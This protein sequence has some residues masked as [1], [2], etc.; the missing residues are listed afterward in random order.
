MTK[1]EGCGFSDWSGKRKT[2]VAFLLFVCCFLPA[3]LIAGP[4]FGQEFAVHEAHTELVNEV[5]QLDAWIDIRLGEEVVDA[6]QS[7]VPITIE[8]DIEVYRPRRYLWNERIASLRQR[9]RLEYHA[10]SE[11]YLV[12][13]LN[14]R[15]QQS[16]PIRGAAIAAVGVIN[17][18]PV[19]D[20]KL[21]TEGK[22][23]MARLRARLDIEALPA[24]LRVLAY[25][26]PSWRASSTWY[27][28]EL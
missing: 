1:M 8:I 13:N 4:A 19:L 7:G 5:Y 11:R 17:D 24:P 3:G 10:L 26:S 6:L 28:W 22:G 16:Y 12:T 14:T 23:Y 9:Y 25:L 2:S 21:L 20:R 15:A 18:L 27:A